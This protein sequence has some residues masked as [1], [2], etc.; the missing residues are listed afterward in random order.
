M[1]QPTPQLPAFDE[2]H[3][4]QAVDK[5]TPEQVHTLPYGAI[6]LDEDGKAV[7]YSDAER[8][9]SGYRKT[10]LGRDFLSRSRRA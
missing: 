9:L 8:R 10:V 6:R 5:L 4:A 1:T 2:P 3:L 7:F